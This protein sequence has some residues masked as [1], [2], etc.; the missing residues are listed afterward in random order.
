MKVLKTIKQFGSAA[1]SEPYELLSE[2]FNE[3]TVGLATVDPQ[4][5]FRTVNQA[6]AGM[7]GVVPEKL[8]GKT[9]HDVIGRAAVAFEVPLKHVFSTGLDVWNLE[10]SAKLP[11]RNEIGY[12]I[13][14]CFAIR[15]GTTSVK[16]VGAITVEITELRKLQQSLCHVTN[17]LFRNLLLSA[18]DSDALL[19]RVMQG[20]LAQLPDERPNS[21]HLAETRFSTHIARQTTE[22]TVHLVALTP[23]E[24][25]V[26]KLLAEGNGNKQTAIRLGITVKTVETH[27]ARIMLKLGLHSTPDLVRY[28]LSNNILDPLVG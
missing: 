13:H 20:S 24:Q 16:H 22:H 21:D 9:I 26:V 25:D 10:I 12:W 6:F 2:L 17:S 4:L 15:N 11:T 27:R 28:A 19:Q 18:H 1:P 8:L 5:R 14:S 7:T 23:R 3:P